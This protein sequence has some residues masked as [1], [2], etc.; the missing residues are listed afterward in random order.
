[1][2]VIY[3]PY[4][5]SYDVAEQG[6][7][8]TSCIVLHGGYFPILAMCC[9]PPVEELEERRPGFVSAIFLCGRNTIWNLVDMIRHNTFLG[10][11][12]FSFHSKPMSL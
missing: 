8:G 12:S 5:A 3:L 1:M 9:S 4:F 7:D 11:I 2:D 10:L 6:I